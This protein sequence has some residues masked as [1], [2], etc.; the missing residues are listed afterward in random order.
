MPEPRGGARCVNP[1]LSDEE[2]EFLGQGPKQRHTGVIRMEEINVSLEEAMI[3][4]LWGMGDG[5][6]DCQGQR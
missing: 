3:K 4:R 1:P 6:Q 5:G 2:F